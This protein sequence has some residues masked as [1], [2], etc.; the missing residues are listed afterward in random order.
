M[1]I[2]LVFRTVPYVKSVKRVGIVILKTLNA[3]GALER[4]HFRFMFALRRRLPQGMLKLNDAS[5]VQ[6]CCTER[7]TNTCARVPAD[8]P[9]APDGGGKIGGG[10]GEGFYEVLRTET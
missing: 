1:E 5:K 6:S 10:S 3:G 8:L 9:Q 2:M 4:L 7:S